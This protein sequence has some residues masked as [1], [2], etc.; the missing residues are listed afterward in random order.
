MAN[1][2]KIKIG[3][4]VMFD[5]DSQESLSGKITEITRGGRY[6][7]NH[8]IRCDNWVTYLGKLTRSVNLKKHEFI[9][10]D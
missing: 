3:L 10:I 1:K 6:G 4:V 9:V 7:N 8:I 5:I 2:Q